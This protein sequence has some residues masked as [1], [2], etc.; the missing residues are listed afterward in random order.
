MFIIDDI[1][2]S[3]LNGF[4]MIAK[5]IHKAANQARAAD[6]QA[7]TNDLSALYERLDRGE[8]TEDEF[9]E[10]EN[11]LLDRLE[12]LEGSDV[13]ADDIDDDEDDDGLTVMSLDEF[14]WLQDQA[15]SQAD[16]QNGAEDDHV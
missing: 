1:L 3:P 8:I 12:A 15:D 13:E 7:I 2:M 10:M 11:A 6:A 5:E 16:S 4:M 14:E 9:D